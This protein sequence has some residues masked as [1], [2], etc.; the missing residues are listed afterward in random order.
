MRLHFGR[1]CSVWP[2]PVT[3]RPARAI[4]ATSEIGKNPTHSR[5]SSDCWRISRPASGAISMHTLIIGNRSGSEIEE[6]VRC[7]WRTGKAEHAAHLDFVSLDD[8]WK[9]LNEKRRAIIQ[10]MAGAGPC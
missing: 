9:L 6:R 7:A 5:P 10:A 2:W 3:T 1:T 4:T 8:A